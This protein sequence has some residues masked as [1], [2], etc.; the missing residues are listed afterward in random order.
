M[1]AAI[2]PGAAGRCYNVGCGQS[3]TLNE[4]LQ[5]LGRLTD[6]QVTPTYTDPRAGDIKDS[7]A[8]IGRIREEL[9]YDPGVGLEEGLGQLLEFERSR[10]ATR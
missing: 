9:G 7:L 4:L 10:R 2:T 1:L 3:T 6:Q 5:V 8:D